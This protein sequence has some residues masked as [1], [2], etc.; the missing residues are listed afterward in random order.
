MFV[1]NTLTCLIDHDFVTHNATDR[2]KASHAQA[3]ATSINMY[4]VVWV[5]SF[6]SNPCKN[7]SKYGNIASRVMRKTKDLG[8]VLG[9]EGR[10]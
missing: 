9:R 5:P 2:E 7:F 8:C 4:L 10:I 1:T 6:F 3:P